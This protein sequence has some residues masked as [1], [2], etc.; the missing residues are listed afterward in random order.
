MPN[1]L[2]VLVA[3]LWT[4]SVLSAE[5]PSETG[6]SLESTPRHEEPDQEKNTAREND[7]KIEKFQNAAQPLGEAP[8]SAVQRQIAKG[9]DEKHQTEEETDRGLLEGLADQD[10]WIQP[11]TSILITFFTGFGVWLLNRTLKETGEAVEIARKTHCVTE[12]A[13]KDTRDGLLL[14]QQIAE[15]SAKTTI[16]EF[17][18]YFIFE[19]IIPHSLGNIWEAGC[20]VSFSF[21]LCNIGKSIATGINF[22]RKSLIITVVWEAQQSVPVD[23]VTVNDIYVSIQPGQPVRMTLQIQIPKAIGTR[24]QS[25]KL[26]PNGI[27]PARK[28]LELTGSF[29]FKDIFD[30]WHRCLFIIGNE[31]HASPQPERTTQQSESARILGYERISADEAISA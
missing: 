31:E 22:D 8:V 19:E 28:T 2:C 30:Q 23:M 1:V 11:L 16:A 7:A 4:T 21:S 20:H 5:L 29:V 6:A 13:L 3:C 10:D 24:L 27:F 14:N 15:R 12:Q 9:I 26:G 25:E 18:P 17:Q